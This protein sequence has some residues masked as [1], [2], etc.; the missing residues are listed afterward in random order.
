MPDTAELFKELELCRMRIY[1]E[2]MNRE[3]M[4]I[5]DSDNTKDITQKKGID[6][7][8][9]FMVLYR[10]GIKRKGTQHMR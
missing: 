4:G 5:G 3:C 6:C 10:V 8:L 9:C 2:V 7:I 1:I